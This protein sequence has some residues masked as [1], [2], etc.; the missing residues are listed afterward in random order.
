MT[1]TRR[2]I[3]F[4]GRLRWRD[5][6]TSL[7]QADGR[8]ALRTAAVTLIDLELF[9]TFRPREALVQ[10]LSW[11]SQARVTVGVDNLLD[12]KPRVEDARGETPAGRTPDDLD[13]LGR[14]FYLEF[15][16]LLR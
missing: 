14:V 2:G 13:P 11:L 6:T 5:G 3:G 1:F 12:D 15:R 10:R 8:I 9:R 7:P 4:R 16:R